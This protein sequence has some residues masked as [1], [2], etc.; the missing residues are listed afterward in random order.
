MTFCPVPF[1]FLNDVHEY[2]YSTLADFSSFL[3]AE[4]NSEL[5]CGGLRDETQIIV[6]DF[7]AYQWRWWL[8]GTKT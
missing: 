5:F 7:D 3:Y 6:S 2:T 8:V 4:R 1:N